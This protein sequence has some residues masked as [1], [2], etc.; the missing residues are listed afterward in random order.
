[1]F[2]AYIVAAYDEDEGEFQSIT[3]IGTGFKD[4]DL[5][6]HN[7]FFKNC[8]AESKPSSYVCDMKPDVWFHPKQVWEVRAAD[9][10][11]SPIHK[12]GE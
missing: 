11:I 3:K 7:A 8:I 9:L 5:E 10:S 4:Q 6:T 1:M 12:A 2:G